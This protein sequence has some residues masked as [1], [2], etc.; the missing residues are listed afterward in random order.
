MN[1]QWREGTTSGKQRQYN[2][3]PPDGKEDSA[4]NRV[5]KKCFLAALGR[6]YGKALWMDGEDTPGERE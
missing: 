4:I 6:S 3:A 1:K 5:L 2:T